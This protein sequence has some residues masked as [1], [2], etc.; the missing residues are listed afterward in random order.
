QKGSGFL[1]A[2]HAFENDLRRGMEVDE[3]AVRTHEFQGS[4]I[5]QRSATERRDHR[6]LPADGAERF[7]FQRAESRFAVGGENV[8]DRFSRPDFNQLVGIEKLPAER[9][10]RE[11]AD[12]A[13]ARGHE[14]R[15]K[16]AARQGD[17]HAFPPDCETCW[18][19]MPS[20]K[21]AGATSPSVRPAAL[22][23]NSNAT[24]P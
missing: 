1:L 17:L 24:L 19:R 12:A 13:L 5:Q 16:N 4:G 21:M 9:G 2:V 7:H 10:G 18:R 8:R 6:P 11:R 3:D 20:W 15:E 14:A 23:H 22:I